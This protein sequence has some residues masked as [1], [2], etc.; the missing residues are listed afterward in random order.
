MTQKPPVWARVLIIA[1]LALVG[2][3]VIGLLVWAGVT[4]WGQVF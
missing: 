2:W 4:V 3:V 1:I